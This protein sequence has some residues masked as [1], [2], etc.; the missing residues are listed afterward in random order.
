MTANTLQDLRA[1]IYDPPTPQLWAR[2]IGLVEG[3]PDE[4]LREIAVQYVT[5][6]LEE[7]PALLRLAPRLWWEA[8]LRG[9]PV[10]CWA[11]VRGVDV[12]SASAGA[13]RDA[14]AHPLMEGLDAL[15]ARSGLSGA[16]LTALLKEARTDDLRAVDLSGNALGSAGAIRELQ[17]RL[18]R[19]ELLKLRDNGLSDGRVF[20]ID[21][22]F[23]ALRTLD[24]SENPITAD[25]LRGLWFTHALERL[26]TLR[27]DDAG[28]DEVVAEGFSD[29]AAPG[30]PGLR[31]L[32][33]AGNA[34]S[35]GG[36]WELAE[37]PLL[38]SLDTLDLSR[39]GLFWRDLRGLTRAV[40]SMGLDALIL[41]GNTIED[42]GVPFLVG[43]GALRDLR[44]LSLARNRITDQGA[45]QLAEA[46]W[47]A[48]LERLDLSENFIGDAGA[49]AL[50]DA[51]GARWSKV[52]VLRGNTGRR[53]L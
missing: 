11:W 34:L 40:R 53:A 44:H 23:A 41:D 12:S 51:L 10:L 43:W 37:S 6:F 17:R 30:L 25:T 27:I 50:R 15:A 42:E 29:I 21:A 24:L 18:P 38:G 31:H 48:S 16:R 1:L 32:A 52:L 45:H 33:L 13:A 4:S 9:E 35:G 39:N 26:H 36:L 5:P 47:L 22:P 28:I 46:P 2:L 19:V 14:L 49:Q 3:E 20:D 8:K 7:W